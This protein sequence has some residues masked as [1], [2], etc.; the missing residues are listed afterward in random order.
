MAEVPFH[1]GNSPTGPACMSFG[2]TKFPTE[3]LRY[4]SNCRQGTLTICIHLPSALLPALM[5]RFGARKFFGTEQNVQIRLI[6]TASSG[7]AWQRE[8][9]SPWQKCPHML[10][11]TLQHFAHLCNHFAAVKFFKSKQ[12]ATI[13][14]HHSKIPATSLMFSRL[15]FQCITSLAQSKK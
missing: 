11:S 6:S 13:S 2:T 8:T 9:R 15:C 5:F 10:F 14:R 4:A 1:Q 7:S 3:R 12:I